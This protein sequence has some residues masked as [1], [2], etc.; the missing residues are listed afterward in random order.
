MRPYFLFKGEVAGSLTTKIVSEATYSVPAG[1]GSGEL[2]VRLVDLAATF[3]G[4]GSNPPRF[5]LD[6]G[7]ITASG[8]TTRTLVDT[9]DI[10]STQVNFEI[11]GDR[12]RISVPDRLGALHQKAPRTRETWPEMPVYEEGSLI[13]FLNFIYKD[14]LG[15][16]QVITNL[17]NVK[18][19]RQDILPTSS[20]HEVAQRAIAIFE[21]LVLED[22]IGNTV[23]VLDPDTGQVVSPQTIRARRI[24]TESLPSQP[25]PIINQV[26]VLYNPSSHNTGDTSDETISGNCPPVF[27]QLAQPLLALPG[28]L[29]ALLSMDLCGGA[30]LTND[31]ITASGAT[32]KEDIITAIMPDGGYAQTTRRYA[33]WY[34][35]QDNPTTPTRTVEIGSIVR[36][37]GPT[38]FGTYGGQLVQEVLTEYF[39]LPG[40][41][42]TISTGS[43]TTTKGIVRLPA[44]GAQF[45]DPV[46][47][48]TEY[49]NYERRTN[50][51]PGQWREVSRVSTTKGL[52]VLPDKVPLSVS[53]L[54]GTVD[55]STST[56]QYAEEQLISGHIEYAGKSGSGQLAITML[57]YNFQRDCWEYS[58]TRPGYGDVTTNANPEPAVAVYYNENLITTYGVRKRAQIDMSSFGSSGLAIGQWK[59]DRYFARSGK[60]RKRVNVRV[61]APLTT[62]Y[63][64]AYISLVDRTGASVT[65]LVLGYTITF[66][67]ITPRGQARAYTE[68]EAIEM[69]AL[70]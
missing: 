4:S 68:I 54:N 62:L 65:Y 9:R 31:D 28:G 67:D 35:D 27:A 58:G 50:D 69:N 18:I 53:S 55:T 22:A 25:Y 16:T 1:I 39:F 43:K 19:P 41:N 10:H 6:V 56:G 49:I 5:T 23:Y 24:E 36:I 66:S 51:P 11:E 37:W 57:D 26:E 42:F 32:I 34:D 2:S 30:Q 20:Y 29:R 46:T 17:P 21:P 38:G 3:S 44:A 47:T 40:S 59:K 15:F 45:I 52:V 64:G 33:N 61:A 60:S 63:R 48:T 13:D 14:K 8:N 70:S 12:L 7:Y